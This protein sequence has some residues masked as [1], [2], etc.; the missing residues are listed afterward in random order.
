[1]TIYSTNTLKQYLERIFG[2]FEKQGCKVGQG[3]FFTRNWYNDRTMPQ[4]FKT[5]LWDVLNIL[6]QNG[7]ITADKTNRLPFLKLS[8]SGFDYIQ[9]GGLSLEALSLCEL[10]DNNQPKDQQYETL[11]RFIGKEDEAPFYLSGKDFFETIAPHIGLTS[12]SYGQYTRQL[13]EEGKS[14]SRRDWFRQLFEKLPNDVVERFLNDISLT[15]RRIY[16]PLL[17]REEVK[18]DDIEELFSTSKPAVH[19]PNIVAEGKEEAK[20]ERIPKVFVIYT[21]EDEAHNKWV[22]NLC[23]RLRTHGGTNAIIDRFITNDDTFPKFMRTNITESDFIVM[24]G[25]PEYKRKFDD[26]EGGGGYEARLLQNELAKHPDKSKIIPV[27][28]SGT[29][30]TSFPLEYASNPGVDF[31]NEALFEDKLVELERKIWVG[32]DVVPAPIGMKPKFQ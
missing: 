27:L 14:T 24:V 28:R 26:L 31:T 23:Q 13:H 7:H 32:Q 1:M 10:I 18:G 3:G 4:G 15:I 5:H 11:W 21:H 8:Q 12:Y 17:N 2:A 9:G 20:E 6:I 29:F 25:T 22:L 16:A 19:T 30:D